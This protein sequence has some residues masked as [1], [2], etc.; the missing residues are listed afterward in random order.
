[1]VQKTRAIPSCILLG[2][3]WIF[4]C[5]R[6]S[7]ILVTDSGT[8]LKRRFLDE[9]E[10]A[11]TLKIP[12]RFTGQTFHSV[13]QELKNYWSMVWRSP[14]DRGVKDR[15]ISRPC[16][17]DAHYFRSNPA[18]LLSLAQ[19][20]HY[21]RFD[22]QV[23]LTLSHAQKDF[24]RERTVELIPRFL[25]IL[26]QGRNF[27]TIPRSRSI[28]GKFHKELAE[29]VFEVK[30]RILGEEGKN[31][32]PEGYRKAIYQVFH[33]ML[34]GL[35]GLPQLS[36]A[37]HYWNMAKLQDVATKELLDILDP[38]NVPLGAKQEEFHTVIAALDQALGKFNLQ[39][40]GQP[41]PFFVRLDS[42]KLATH[43]FDITLVAYELMAQRLYTGHLNQDL[44]WLSTL[45]YNENISPDSLKAIKSE[46]RTLTSDIPFAQEF[47]D[48][49]KRLMR[50]HYE[51]PSSS[52]SSEESPLQ[53]IASRTMVF[54][55][56]LARRI[57][58]RQF[59]PK[60]ELVKP[61]NQ[62][63]LKHVNR[64]LSKINK[65][66]LRYDPLISTP[67][68]RG[69]IGPSPWVQLMERFH[70]ILASSSG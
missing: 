9:K 56:N 32:A 19:E 43:L 41:P 27:V 14:R 30:T 31:T 50:V 48:F 59:Q 38:Q 47:D 15:V 24:S 66:I 60:G 70:S 8:L 61:D 64:V 23:G 39:V 46:W 67:R 22:T 12:K 17:I 10:A 33:R 34:E 29:T 3:L 11:S 2:V 63:Q 65:L 44:L 26:I 28:N 55:D 58:W 16:T 40:Q 36:S 45:S 35:E 5:A 54:S 1:M 42:E 62:I 7:A 20:E 18:E 53:D 13:A 68:E 4:Y 49:Q 69:P 6:S 52:T 21:D 51:T 25:N 57:W 37:S